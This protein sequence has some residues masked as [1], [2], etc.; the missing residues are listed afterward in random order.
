MPPLLS[1]FAIGKKGF[2]AQ[3][4]ASLRNFVAAPETRFAILLGVNS[5]AVRS[6]KL[7]KD[8]AEFEPKWLRIQ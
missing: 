2:L 7:C 8:F 5:Q 6:A 4:F 1:I 3:V